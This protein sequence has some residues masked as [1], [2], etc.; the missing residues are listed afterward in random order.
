MGRCKEC[1]TLACDPDLEDW[2]DVGE[3]CELEMAVA[4]RCGDVDAPCVSP[5]DGAWE[6]LRKE[7]SGMFASP[8]DQLPSFGAWLLEPSS[9]A[10]LDE[11]F[12]CDAIIALAMA[13][14]GVGPGMSAVDVYLSMAVSRFGMFRDGDLRGRPSWEIDMCNLEGVAKAFDVWR[15]SLR[16]ASPAVAPVPPVSPVEDHGVIY[17]FTDGDRIVYIGQTRERPWSNRFRSHVREARKPSTPFHT[18]L[19]EQV[20]AGIVPSARVVETVPASMLDERERHWISEYRDS[21]LNVV[22]CRAA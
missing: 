11:H 14:E 3:W 2:E 6:M 9:L 13:D 4:I 17:A 8:L 21:L 10:L 22:H 19:R 1:D 5:F 7:A 16:A 12:E 20:D 15:A 18:W